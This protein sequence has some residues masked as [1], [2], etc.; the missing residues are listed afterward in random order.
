MV[1]PG[2][3][4]EAGM[5]VRTALRNF[6][7]S[8]LPWSDGIQFVAQLLRFRPDSVRDVEVGDIVDGV[9]SCV[10]PAGSCY[11]N[12]NTEKGLQLWVMYSGSRLL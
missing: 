5:K 10:C 8:Y 6:M 11:R 7:D 4:I 12:L 1:F 2:C 3:C 9:Y